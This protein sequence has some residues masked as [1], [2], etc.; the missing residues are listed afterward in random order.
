MRVLRGHKRR[1]NSSNVYSLVTIFVLVVD[2]GTTSDD[3]ERGGK[4]VR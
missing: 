4:N 3:V 2:G 1:N